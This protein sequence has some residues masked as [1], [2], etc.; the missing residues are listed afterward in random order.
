M[1]SYLLLQFSALNKN[2]HYIFTVSFFYIQFRI[3]RYLDKE[4]GCLEQCHDSNIADSPHFTAG[5]RS[6]DRAGKRNG[7]KA[8]L[9]RYV[10]STLLSGD[11]GVLKHYNKMSIIFEYGRKTAHRKSGR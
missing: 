6:D 10:Y 3:L 7:C 1:H 8:S 9:I 2:R 11:R 5:L 4:T